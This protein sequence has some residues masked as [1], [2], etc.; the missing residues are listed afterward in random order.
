MAVSWATTARL[1]VGTW[2]E[3]RPEYAR[4][5][6][7]CLTHCPVGNDVEGFV[8]RVRDGNEE[9]AAAILSAETPFP[10]VCGRVCYHPCETACNRVQHDGP[11]GIRAIERYLGDL[12]YFDRPGVWTAACP[13]TGRRVAVVGAGP[14]GLAAAWALA[15]LGHHV[16][17]LERADEPGG[18][19]R[20]GIPAYRLPKDILDREIERIRGLGVTIRC[21]VH[22]G[23]T[24]N[25][26]GLL[27][28]YNAVFAFP[29]SISCRRSHAEPSLGSATA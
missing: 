1:P 8:S 5:L 28:S 26:P 27:D 22:V 7:P 4:Q 12:A 17:I 19:L 25:L 20:Y 10:A 13:P 21:G 24:E 14:A 29:R 9:S 2:A 11:V 15:L 3:R 6:S 18:L 23:R 16:E